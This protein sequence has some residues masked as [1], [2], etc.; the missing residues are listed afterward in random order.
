M[1]QPSPSSLPSENFQRGVI[2]ALVAVPAG[3]IAW[4]IIWSVGFIASIVGFGV[5]WF[6][7]RLYRFGSGGRISRNG[8][9]AVTVI[10]VVTLLLAF[11]SGY[12]I[13]MV[14]Q[15]TQA[16]GGSIPEGLVD[17]RVW[18]FAFQNMVSGQAIVSLLLA[19]LFGVL[20]CF[21]ILRGAFRQARMPQ[22]APQY[23]APQYGAPQYGAPQFGT[24]AGQPAQQPTLMNP[25]GTPAVPPPPAPGTMLNGQPVDDQQRDARPDPDAK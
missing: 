19:A 20:G 17:S 13:D 5:A 4:D 11:I 18:S 23:G 24:P 21:S 15:F 16:T 6:A 12:V 10:T 14:V 2:F 25:E 9:I 22:D 8:A 3:V 1:T 7:V